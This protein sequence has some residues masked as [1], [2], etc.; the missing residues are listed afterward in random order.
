MQPQ[1]LVP[2]DGSPRAEAI[3]ALAVPLAHA[4]GAGLT[5]VQALGADIGI[6]LLVGMPLPPQ[7]VEQQQ[8]QAHQA[9]QS[10]LRETAQR[11]AHPGWPVQIAIVD[12]APVPAIL[13][14]IDHHPEVRLIAM[15]THGRRAVNRLIFGSVAEEILHAAPL[16][17]LLLRQPAGTPVEG[18]EPVFHKIVVPLDGSP[19]AE[20]ALEQAKALARATAASLLLVTAVEGVDDASAATDEIPVWVQHERQAEID[21]LVVYQQDLAAR[22]RA[23]GLKVDVQ[24]GAGRPADVIREVS[25]AG[26]ASLIVMATHGRTGF[27]R[28][29]LGCVALEVLE[30]AAQPVF[31]VRVPPGQAV[32]DA[33]LTASARPLNNRVERVDKVS[34]GT[35]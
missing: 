12:G 25:S 9:A 7:A 33:L 23:E 28:L 13:G 8:T 6:D 29:R 16:P 24:V 27:G 14:Y 26:N 18:P 34:A 35:H 22:I 2:L 30:H 3:L 11:L 19:F 4:T 32:P 1:I 10:Y 17:L 15:T 5:L 31:L 21:R 20:Y